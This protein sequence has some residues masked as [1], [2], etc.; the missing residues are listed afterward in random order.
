MAV[1][2][3]YLFDRW[4]ERIGI[5]PTLGSMTHAEELGGEDTLEFGCLVAPEKGDRLLWRDPESGTWREHEV[6]RTDE[7][8]TGASHVYA[9][10]SLCELLRDYVE[11]EQLV[12]KTASQAMTAVLG[13]TRWSL[14]TVDVGDAKRGA[15]L[16]HTNALAALRRVESVWGGELQCSVGVDDG[17]VATRTVSLLAR[18]GAWHGAR[19]TYGRNLAGCTRT[20]LEDEVFTALYGWG[21]GLPVEDDEG[22][23]TGG[24]TRRLNYGDVNDNVKWV[25]DDEARL[26]WGRWDAERGE[27]VHSFGQVVFPECENP[28]ELLALTKA[29]LKEVS[30]PQVSYECDAVMVDGGVPVGLGDDVAV[31]D[32][33]RTPEWRLT[34]RCVRRV[35]TFGAGKPRCHVT[36][37]TVERATWE[38]SAEIVQRVSA[39]EETA[40]TAS[41]SVQSFD[42]LSSKE[43]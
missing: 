29:R 21:K 22:N 33:S 35:R 11:E 34:A 39:V 14:G 42:D 15:L 38:T 10:S 4:D 13:H 25:G 5:L 43:F 31:I 6:V 19:F 30:H 20:V 17:R 12:S 7:P 16:Y 27:R 40:A 26:R 41:D 3:L 18:R 23:A 1:P 32:T 37:G 28:E 24:Y 36:L 2:T 9:E 8:L